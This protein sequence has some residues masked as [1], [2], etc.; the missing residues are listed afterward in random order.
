[1]YKLS[2]PVNVTHPLTDIDDG[3]D[4]T[5]S[6]GG[7]TSK[8]GSEELLEEDVFGVNALHAR[9]VMRRIKMGPNNLF[10]V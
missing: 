1:M 4:S 8:T 6:V 2:L 5:L 3:R 10:L 7:L 9:L